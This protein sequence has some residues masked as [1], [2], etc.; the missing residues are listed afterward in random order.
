MLFR[1]FVTKFSFMLGGTLQQG[2]FLLHF[3]KMIIPHLLKNEKRIVEK[4]PIRIFY[5]YLNKREKVKMRS[6][7]VS[8]SGRIT[9]DSLLQG[10]NQ[11]KTLEKSLEFT[12]VV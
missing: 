6:M 11:E 7:K 3:T 12:Y 4:M 5:L 8:L 1:F 2:K 10:I 9:I